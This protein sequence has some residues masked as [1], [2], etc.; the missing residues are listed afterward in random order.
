MDKIIPW[1]LW[2]RYENDQPTDPLVLSDHVAAHVDF[3]SIT[4]EYKRGFKADGD[5]VQ[6][7]FVLQAVTLH[8][9][10]L[11]VIEALEKQPGATKWEFNFRHETGT[12]VGESHWVA[13]GMF[14]RASITTRSSL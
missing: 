2:G 3:E 1:K 8:N 9:D 13:P 12:V 11:V 14:S 5:P 7:K 6:R 4:Y 10:D